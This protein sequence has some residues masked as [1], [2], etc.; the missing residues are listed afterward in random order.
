MRTR[1]GWVGRAAVSARPLAVLILTTVRNA[2]V[3]A[4]HS[5]RDSFPV[6]AL[7]SFDGAVTARGGRP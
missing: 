7:A 4:G 3:P 5:P 2:E 6:S 1:G